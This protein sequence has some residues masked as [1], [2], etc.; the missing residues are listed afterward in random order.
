MF[1]HVDF[2]TVISSIWW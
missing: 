1:Y 2:L